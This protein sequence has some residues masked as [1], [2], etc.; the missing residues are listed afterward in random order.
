MIVVGISLHISFILGG[1]KRPFPINKYLGHGGSTS[2]PH[3]LLVWSRI[4]SMRA[5]FGK[6][7]MKVSNFH[8]QLYVTN[9]QI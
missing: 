7:P 8:M 6:E 3:D 1:S 9:F 5:N 4:L 2:N